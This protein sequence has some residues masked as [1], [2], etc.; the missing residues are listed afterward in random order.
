MCSKT[1]NLISFQGSKANVFEVFGRHIIFYRPSSPV[2]IITVRK[3][4]GRLL[5]NQTIQI[6]WLSDTKR[7]N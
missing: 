7:I 2:L 4:Y 3:S 5:F 1:R 6:E